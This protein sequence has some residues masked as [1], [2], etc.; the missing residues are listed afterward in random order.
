MEV[1]RSRLEAGCRILREAMSGAWQLLVP[2]AVQ[3]RV[4]PSWGEL[5]PLEEEEE[6]T[7]K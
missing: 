5:S 3:L 7:N 4:G 2:L 6:L 1:E